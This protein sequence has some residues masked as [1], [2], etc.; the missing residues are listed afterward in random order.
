MKQL[1]IT[2]FI[3]AFMLL[4]STSL[5]AKS[6]RLK[7]TSRFFIS[8]A[9]ITSLPGSHEARSQGLASLAD[10]KMSFDLFNGAI[11]VFQTRAYKQKT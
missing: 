11:K 3:A 8:V 1:G 9:K 4:F 10:K 2:K 6:P 5:I 7:L